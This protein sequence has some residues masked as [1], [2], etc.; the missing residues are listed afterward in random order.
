MQA[1]AHVDGT[2]SEGRR[3]TAGDRECGPRGRKGKEE[4]VSLGVDLDP[5]LGGADIADHSAMLGQS[6]GVALRAELVQQLRRTFDVGEEEGD[7]A[8]WKVVSHAR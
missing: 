1:D 3:Q 6:R 5:T 2:R 7:R 8:G 4:G